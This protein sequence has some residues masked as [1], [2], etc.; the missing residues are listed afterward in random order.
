MIGVRSQRRQQQSAADDRRVVHGA[1]LVLGRVGRTVAGHPAGVEVAADAVRAFR[2]GEDDRTDAVVGVDRLPG[3]GEAHQHV[4]RERV[5]PGRPVHRQDDSGALPV[6][7]QARALRQACVET[8]PEAAAPP[9]R[10]P[11]QTASEPVADRRNPWRHSEKPAADVLDVL[12]QRV[13]LTERPL[14][15]HELLARILL[16][17]DEEQAGVELPGRRV[18]AVGVG[19]AAAQDL[20]AAVVV[21]AGEPDVRVGRDDRLAVLRLRR[22]VDRVEFALAGERRAGVLEPAEDVLLVGAG[23]RRPS[24][25]SACGSGA[26]TR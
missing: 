3:V 20:L 14:D 23:S 24:S 25:R 6:V 4:Q 1:A 26:T 17:R 13:V 8:Y 7:D 10:L 16:E 19:V 11:E 21:R 2:A 9:Q 22:K 18:V 15:R 12:V 5:A